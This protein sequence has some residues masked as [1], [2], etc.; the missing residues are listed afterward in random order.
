[1][2]LLLLLI[3]ILI[4]ACVTNPSSTPKLRH[5]TSTCLQGVEKAT[6][7]DGVIDARPKLDTC[8]EVEDLN[9]GDTKISFNT[10]LYCSCTVEFSTNIDKDTLIVSREIIG[11]ISLCIC[12][13]QISL[14][15]TAFPD[16][17][18]WL[19]YGT[20]YYTRK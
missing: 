12:P 2:K 15:L 17:I 4:Q 10:Y 16:S 3:I 9:T 14:F 1:M 18:T 6:T 7:D 8:F 5:E 20:H 11:S 13:R 19:K